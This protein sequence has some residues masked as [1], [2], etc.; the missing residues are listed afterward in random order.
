MT[1]ELAALGV[2]LIVWLSL[3]AVGFRAM[4]RRGWL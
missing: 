4:V 1:P 2:S 3:S